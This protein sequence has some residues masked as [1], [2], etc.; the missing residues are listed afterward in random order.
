MKLIL[1]IEDKTEIERFLLILNV[2]LINSLKNGLISIDEAENFM[3]T[4]YSLERIKNLGI[5]QEII[6]L[7]QEGCE[8]ENID[9]IIKDQLNQTLDELENKSINKLK[10]LS[11]A[12]I[13]VKKW[14]D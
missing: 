1:S 7:F 14:I 9:R 3:Y 4:P 2:G 12:L 10:N 5:E 11:K 6:E 8:L 13:P